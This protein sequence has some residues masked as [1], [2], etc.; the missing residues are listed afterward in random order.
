[1]CVKVLLGLFVKEYKMSWYI[2]IQER[3][4]YHPTYKGG[5]NNWRNWR[6]FSV[7]PLLF[8]TQSQCNDFIE[9]C[10]TFSGLNGH[11]MSASACS[12]KRKTT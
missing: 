11:K 8:D 6:K 3:A 2:R 7:W 12:V 1:M 5:R 9:A 4:D 10:F